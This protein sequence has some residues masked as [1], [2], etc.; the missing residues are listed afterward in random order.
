MALPPWE[1]QV[2]A[3][4]PELELEKVLLTG[5]DNLGQILKVGKRQILC[6]K[7]P[8][9]V[10]KLPVGAVANFQDVSNIQQMEARIRQ[11]IYTSGHIASFTFDD[12]SG[13][14]D[15]IHDTVCTA[16]AFAVAHSGVLIIGETGTGKEVFAQ[17]IHNH[18]QRSKGPFVAINCAA[19]PSQLLESELFG[20]VAGA[21]TGGKQNRQARVV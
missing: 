2:A 12:V 6:N 1:N 10:N 8:I 21:F 3:V 4:W 18:S 7:V 17:S 20:Y 5:E 13:D 16:K 9:L 15:V 14:T 11:E 19:L